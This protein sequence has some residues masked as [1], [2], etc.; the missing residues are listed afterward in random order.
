MWELVLDGDPAVD[1]SNNGRDDLVGNIDDCLDHQC[2]RQVL[3]ELGHI[4]GAEFRLGGVVAKVKSSKVRVLDELHVFREVLKAVN[5]LFVILEFFVVN[6]EL[7][8]LADILLDLLG[9]I[10]LSAEDSEVNRRTMVLALRLFSRGL[11]RFVP[12]VIIIRRRSFRSLL[13][14][15]LNIL[16]LGLLLYVISPV[17]DVLVHFWTK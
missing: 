15:L 9:C 10:L 11:R 16:W 13:P 7:Q 4:P 2:D 1:V 14:L 17:H 3:L 5:S 6:Q 8:R 12:P